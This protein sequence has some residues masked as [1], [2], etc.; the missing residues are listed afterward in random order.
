MSATLSPVLPTRMNELC[1]KFET[2]G[3]IHYIYRSAVIDKAFMPCTDVSLT[4]FTIH[5]HDSA[6]IGFRKVCRQIAGARFQT[7]YEVVVRLDQLSQPTPH[8]MDL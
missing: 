1:R 2:G 3:L 6:P 8:R 5:K 4:C 7:A